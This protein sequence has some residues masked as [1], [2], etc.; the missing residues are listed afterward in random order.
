MWSA[1]TNS[2]C[3]LLPFAASC[4]ALMYTPPKGNPTAKYYLA[5]VEEKSSGAVFELAYSGLACAT[6]GLLI[7]NIQWYYHMGGFRSGTLR[8]VTGGE[9]EPALWTLSGDQGSDWHLGSATVN[10]G[11]F[12]FEVVRGNYASGDIAIDDVAV[13]CAEAPPPRPA[14]PIPLVPPSFPPPAPS[15][16]LWEMPVGPPPMGPMPK[17]PPLPPSVPPKECEDACRY[18]SDVSTDANSTLAAPQ[19]VTADHHLPVPAGGL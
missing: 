7:G 12:R 2:C 10:A 5:H 8:V 4:Q 6:A 14:Q 3:L 16:P 9:Q 11:S 18:L 1:A 15:L 17:A 19:A 13:A